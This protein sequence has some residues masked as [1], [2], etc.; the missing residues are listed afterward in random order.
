MAILQ[1]VARELNLAPSVY[2]H[3]ANSEALSFALAA[4][5][6]TAAWSKAQAAGDRAGF[7]ATW[8]SWARRVDARLGQPGSVDYLVENT[9]TYA[10]VAV[11]DAL[12]RSGTQFLDMSNVARELASANAHKLEKLYLDIEGKLARVPLA[13]ARK[14]EL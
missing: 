6:L 2:S 13:A 7:R 4:D 3:A 14:D 11:Y 8:D 12:H 9:L 10:D 1:Y 5:D